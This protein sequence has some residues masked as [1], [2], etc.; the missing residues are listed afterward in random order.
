MIARGIRWTATIFVGLALVAALMLVVGSVMA[1]DELA[2]NR[3]REGGAF[4]IYRLDL[5]HRVS[6]R[7][8]HTGMNDFSPTW[9]P[10]G[11][12]IAYVSRSNL[13][14][15]YDAIYVVTA[16][17]SRTFKVND[18][19]TLSGFSPSLAWSPDATQIAYTEIIN[20]GGTQGI[21]VMDING[22]NRRRVSEENGN[23]FAPSW[24]PDGTRII[25]S[26]SP[27]ANAEIWLT[28][29]SDVQMTGA[30]S[31]PVRLT[32]DYR[33]DSQPAWSPDGSR[34]AFM[35]GRDNNSEIYVMDADGSNLINLSQHEAI[36][37]MP[38]WSSDGQWIA[39][40]SNRE[41]NFE[42]YMVRTDGTQL[43]RLTYNQLTDYTPVFR[44]R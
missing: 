6:A 1:G 40:T 23:A 21:F 25:Y 42:L 15:P 24:S 7:V 9:S 39:F 10:D 11:T 17:G 37:S 13:Y 26:W 43:T 12:Q 44:P 33:M 22:D 20:V 34:I 2:Y 28:N 36:D 30:V 8:T 5:L 31:E 18:V 14:S 3:S 19:V 29:I 38:S 35:S 32:E 4:D 41:S 16:D 27:V